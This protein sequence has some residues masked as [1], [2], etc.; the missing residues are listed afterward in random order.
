MMAEIVI[1][2]THRTYTF[3]TDEQGEYGSLRTIDESELEDPDEDTARLKV[4]AEEL[5]DLLY[6]IDTDNLL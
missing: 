6:P 3:G 4:L 1:Q 5:E 2:S